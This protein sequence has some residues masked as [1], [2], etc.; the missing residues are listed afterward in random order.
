M[1]MITGFLVAYVTKAAP[2][3]LVPPET[4]GLL[5]G[6]SSLLLTF[7]PIGGAPLLEQLILRFELSRFNHFPWPCIPFLNFIAECLMLR[8]VGYGYIFV[9][10]ELLKFLVDG[11][12]SSESNIG[13]G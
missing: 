10:R 6:L 4:Y 12:S 8:K 3:E 11:K 2:A 1:G 13:A 5:I 9:H 7:V